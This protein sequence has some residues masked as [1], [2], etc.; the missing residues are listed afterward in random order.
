MHNNLNGTRI[1]LNCF[2]ENKKRAVKFLR[3]IQ[4]KVTNFFGSKLNDLFEEE[5][6]HDYSS[7]KISLPAVDFGFSVPN[8]IGSRTTLV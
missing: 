6:Q 8:V 7:K 1:L 3:H 2:V 5:R 4:R